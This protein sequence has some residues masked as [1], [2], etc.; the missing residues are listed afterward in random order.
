M[1]ESCPLPPSRAEA[2][3][4]VQF[5]LPRLLPSWTRSLAA[6]PPPEVEPDRFELPEAGGQSSFWRLQAARE[7]WLV[8]A[9]DASG[10]APGRWLLGS[11]GLERGAAVLLLLLW[12]W[13]A[14]G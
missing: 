11:G 6:L 13:G 2:L 1:P 3:D 4:P 7:V 5:K 10:F 14:V 9:L 12:R 8:T